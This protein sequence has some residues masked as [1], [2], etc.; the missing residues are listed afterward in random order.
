VIPIR[1]PITPPEFLLRAFFGT[2]E[3]DPPKAAFQ[4]SW[5]HSFF[6]PKGLAC[7]PALGEGIALVAEAHAVYELRLPRGDGLE[8]EEATLRPTL[9]GCLEEAPHF[10]AAGIRGIAIE[11]AGEV[12]V[13]CSVVLLG[14]QG[15]AALRCP[16]TGSSGVATLWTL[17]GGPWRELSAS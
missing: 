8:T 9:E 1:P 4:G 17:F 15:H 6:V 2:R 10:V 11:C 12:D 16:L 13:A 14:A 5:P 3:P 7:H